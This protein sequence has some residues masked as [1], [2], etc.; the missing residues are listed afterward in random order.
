MHPRM[1][2]TRRTSTTLLGPSIRKVPKKPPP[3]A[4]RD[5]CLWLGQKDHRAP[6]RV[7]TRVSRPRGNSPRVCPAGEARGLR[8]WLSRNDA[9]EPRITL[10]SQRRLGD[11]AP[12]Q[13]VFRRNCGVEDVRRG[14]TKCWRNPDSFSAHSLLFYSCHPCYPWSKAS[15]YFRLRRK[16]WSNRS[17]MPPRAPASWGAPHLMLPLAQSM[18]LRAQALL[19]GAHGRNS[20]ANGRKQCRI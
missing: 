7:R 19:P 6:A 14:V 17:A 15:E 11:T 3:A 5:A 16:G 4:A 2:Q 8:P 13:M 12:R 1:A 18:L 20:G 10:I 9:I